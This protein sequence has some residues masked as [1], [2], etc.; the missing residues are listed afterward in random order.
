MSKSEQERLYKHFLNLSVNGKNDIQKA[1]CKK[2]ADEILESYPE[3]AKKPEVE[4]K[5]DAVIA[6]K[7]EPK[8]K[9]SKK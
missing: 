5:V 2:Y 3:F 9:R 7:E 6:K 4:V 8:S 1:N